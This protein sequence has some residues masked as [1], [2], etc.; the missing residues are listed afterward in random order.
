MRQNSICMQALSG[1][2]KDSARFHQAYGEIMASR[3]PNGRADYGLLHLDHT[4]RLETYS[5]KAKTNPRPA[6][7]KTANPLANV[8]LFAYH[9]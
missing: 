1:K 7:L 6:E 4:H 5:R 9:T 2:T 3:S 8:P